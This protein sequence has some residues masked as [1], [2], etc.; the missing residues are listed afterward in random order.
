MVNSEVSGYV[1]QFF[2]ELIVTVKQKWTQ[3]L[4]QSTQMT[5]IIL[6]NFKTKRSDFFVMVIMCLNLR[7]FG[8]FVSMDTK[9]NMSSYMI[10]FISLS[11]IQQS[12]GS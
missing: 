12:I 1:S 5:S 6:H 2:I 4:A 8:L 11:D 9:D 10:S 3:W 7:T